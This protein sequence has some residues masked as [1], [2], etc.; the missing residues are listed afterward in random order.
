V[1]SVDKDRSH[2]DVRRSTSRGSDALSAPANVRSVPSETR[3]GRAKPR[4]SPHPRHRLNPRALA[5]PI[6]SGDPIASDCSEL[7]PNYLGM[8]T[9]STPATG[10]QHTLDV[11]SRSPEGENT[12]RKV[13]RRYRNHYQ[14]TNEKVYQLYS[15]RIPPAKHACVWSPQHPWGGP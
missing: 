10:P 2:G 13:C 12:A 1:I 5:E 3:S 11:F 6:K 15:I 4:H 14:Q 7:E 8:Q 9:R